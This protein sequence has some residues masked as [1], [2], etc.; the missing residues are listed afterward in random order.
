MTIPDLNELAD[1]VEAL[2][3]PDKRIDVEIEI[4]VAGFPE[5]AYQVNN[6]MRRK[7][8]PHIDRIEFMLSGR[9]TR[10][11]TASL[12]AAMTLVPDGASWSLYDVVGKRESVRMWG[13]GFDVLVSAATPA[14]ALTAAALRARVQS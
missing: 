9:W 13:D 14:L 10:P 2:S 3:G 12:D 7:G 6:S 5:I 1:R 4:L 11:S 8:S